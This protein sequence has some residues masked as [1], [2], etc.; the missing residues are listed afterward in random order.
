MDYPRGKCANSGL[1]L[2]LVVTAELILASVPENSF[3]WFNH[4][5]YVLPDKMR[6]SQAS[7]YMVSPLSR[8]VYVRHNLFKV[9]LIV[10]YLGNASVIVLLINS[11]GS[12]LMQKSYSQ[13]I[14]CPTS[15]KQICL[16]LEVVQTMGHL[17]GIGFFSSSLEL[18]PFAQ[19]T[20]QSF[21]LEWVSC[22]PRR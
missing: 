4:C 21:E 6:D 19:A 11:S 13:S 20:Q 3:H 17:N 9:C 14:G 18:P 16:E 1:L 10:W 22:Y 7:L 12:S 15:T 2:I 8:P 5:C